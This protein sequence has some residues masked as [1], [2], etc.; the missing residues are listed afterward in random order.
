AR[1][2]AERILAVPAQHL[3]PVVEHGAERALVG[4]VAQ[5]AF[6]VTQLEA[7]ARDVDRRQ[8]GGT[9][10]HAGRRRDRG[11]IGHSRSRR[12]NLPTANGRESCASEPAENARSHKA[13]PRN[14]AA[15]CRLSL[16]A[17]AR[18]RWTWSTIPCP[19]VPPRGAPRRERAPSDDRESTTWN[20]PSK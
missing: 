9:V 4:V 19:P 12:S 8:P 16:R 3:A 2:L 10:H 6:R 20:A 5:E 14:R 13:L 17:G 18:M 1:F 11:G 15:A 7:V